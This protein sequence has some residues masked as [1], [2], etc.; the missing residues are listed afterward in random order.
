MNSDVKTRW[1]TAIII[2]LPVLLLLIVGTRWMWWLGLVGVTLLGAREF[3][4]LFKEHLDRSSELVLVLT[5]V[6]F[7]MAAFFFNI[8]GLNLVVF[9]AFL[10]LMA[11]CL[12]FHP[13]DKNLPLRHAFTLFGAIYT[14]YFLSYILLFV[15]PDGTMERGLLFSTIITVV[16]SDAGAFFCGRKWGKHL[17]YPQVS[18]KKTVEGLVGGTISGILLGTLAVII[19]VEGGSLWKA[20]FFA[21]T[22]SIVAPFGDLVESMFKRYWGVKDSG[23]ILPGHGGLLD[24]LD[25]LI[26]AFPAA[27]FYRWLVW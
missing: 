1:T 18:P 2:A 3:Y 27:W 14:G 6:A 8:E 15:R 4:G 26:V 11:H 20:L 10:A 5:S 21:V 19:T 22:V 12:F 16:A 25:S 24:R 7:P 23:N 13:S 9:L 17:L